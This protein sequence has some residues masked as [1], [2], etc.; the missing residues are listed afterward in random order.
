MSSTGATARF[1]FRSARRRSGRIVATV[2]AVGVATA[3]AVAAF[4]LAAQLDR[5]VGT[6]SATTVEDL[7]PEGAVVVTAG[8][9]GATEPTA[10][11]A[12][13]V[14]RV[15]A[16]DGV[17]DA[18]GTYEQPIGVR[19]ERGSQDD[20]PPMLRGLVFSSEW[21]PAR[22]QLLRG[23]AP[24]PPSGAGDAV[25][26]AMDVAGLTTAQADV[27]ETIRLQTPTGGV[28]AVVV[29]EVAST[30][31]SAADGGT[32]STG[33]DPSAALADAHVVVDPGVL[34]AILGAQGRVDR[35]TVTPVPGVGV[36]ELTGRL[37][38]VLPE[39]LRLRSAADPEVAE[40]RA[41]SAVSDGIVTVTWVVALV[42]ALVA[43]LLVANT[44][45][46]VAAQR[47]LEVALARCIGMSRRQV[48]GSFLVEAAVIGA[49]AATIGLLLGLPLSLLAAHVLH[50]DTRSE[51]LLTTPMLVT[52][53]VVGLGV[54][55]LA[56]AVPA[57][58]V[59]RVA[60]ISALDAGRAH[61]GGRSVLLLAVLPVLALVRRLSRGPVLR[62]AAG[63]P[64]RDPR[65]ASAIVGTLFVSL[66]LI[67]AVL[68]VSTSVR[69]SI[70]EQYVASSDADLYLRRRGVVRVDARSLEAR[71]GA[72]GRSGYVDLSRVE[73]TLR[74]PDGAE[75]IV[76]SAELSEVPALFDLELAEATG[77]QGGA[78]PSNGSATS[79]RPDLSG[80]ALLSTRTAT[81]LG[82]ATGDLVTLRSTSGRDVEVE[83]RGT[84]RSSAVVG[85]ALVD[86][87]VVRGVDAEGSFELAAIA[88]D[89]GAPVDEVRRWIDRNVGGFN[90]LG[91]DTPEGFA[92]TDT[93]IAET[94]TRLVLVLLT[95]TLALGAVGAANN[96]A[97]SVAERT[98]ELSM[99]RAVG[100]ARRQVRRLV[101]VEAALLC[102][103]VG[104]VA[105]ASGAAVGVAALRLSPDQ[106]AA[107]ARV[108]W[109]AL[110][111]VVALAVLLGALAAALP[112][113][114]AARRPP[115]EG[116]D[117][118]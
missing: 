58:R 13:L 84:Y 37:A 70:D 92:A 68:T 86:R 118:D 44:L 89:E 94:V 111:A 20:R 78:A 33:V 1:G 11:S 27:G 51:L 8:T 77:P 96:I 93:D 65:R 75:A 53:V 100:A 69:N 34:G 66:V 28:D 81:T 19:I 82:V 63:Q 115:L 56:A 106:L 88:L 4:G 83:V 10:I 71:L 36:D 16:V 43:A 25:P 3:L 38:R 46:I 101:T 107:N 76:R 91:V 7:L 35:I 49:A 57:W 14:D 55:M 97:L 29:A 31:R 52:A 72:E 62:M 80:G 18:S 113:R 67:G 23:V 30:A 98:R 60:P 54:T 105:V 90:R 117:G 6:T 114:A 50:P 64:G 116:L 48:V 15:A 85:P 42:A 109:D 21:D 112:A 22:W 104:S 74:G 95:G 12:Q 17:L 41:V 103:L 73:G 79:G 9:P 26:V 39:D 40:A 108:P 32:N 59:A 61:R 24:T 45:S 47:S 2:L 102:G 87:T 110:A 5:L 99:L